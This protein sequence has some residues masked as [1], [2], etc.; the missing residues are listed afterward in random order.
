[1]TLTRIQDVPI[2]LFLNKKDQFLE[3]VTVIDIG[4]YHPLYTGGLDYGKTTGTL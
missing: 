2:I 4:I 1:M 3:K